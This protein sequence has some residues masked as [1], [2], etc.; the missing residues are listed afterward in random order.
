M[1]NYEKMLDEAYENIKPIS[2]SQRFERFEIP[3]AQAQ[4]IG[5]KTIISNFLQICS[6][7][8]RDPQHVSKFL[9]KELASFSKIEGERLVLNRKIQTAQIN[10]KII[11]YV[12]EFIICHECKKPDTELIKQ[13]DYMF[14]HCL[15]CGAKH[16]VRAKI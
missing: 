14:M 16:S 5:N 9:S 4:I 1:E 3:K 8:R 12:N 15:A 6:Y 13:G 10:D 7:L 11:F 2:V